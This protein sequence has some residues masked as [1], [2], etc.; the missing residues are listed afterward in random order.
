MKAVLD[1]GKTN[2]KLQLVDDSGRALDSFARKNTPLNS[3]PY[4]HADVAGIWSWLLATLASYGRVGEIEALIVTTHGATA[5]LVNENLLGAS[6]DG[7]VLPVLDYEYPAIENCS[8][9]YRALRPPFSETFSPDLPAGLNL[10]RQ[11]FWLEQEFGAEFARASHILMYPQYWAWRL[12]GQLAGEVTSLGCHTDLWA[13]AANRYSSLVERCGWQR[14]LP[15]LQS[16]WQE[17]GLLLPAIALHTGLPS[18]CKIYVGLHDSNASYLR[19]LANATARADYF[20]VISSGTWTILM[21]ARGGVAS[22]N[23][24]RDMLANCDVY[25]D[26][27]PCARF[28]GGREYELI[29]ARLGGDMAAP[30]SAAEVQQAIDQGWMVTPDFSA[31]NGPFGGLEARLNC[32]LPAPSAGAIATLYCALMI[33]QRLSDLGASGPI[34]IEGAFLNN[35][36]LCQLVAQ[37]RSE[38][39]VY[40]SADATGTVQG[41]LLLTRLANSGDFTLELQ[42]CAPA[43]FTGLAEYR[44]QWQ[45]LIAGES[46]RQSI[47]S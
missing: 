28:M 40:L 25:G 39:P 26:P 5:A 10:G 38:Q 20:T 18:G 19:Y 46:E 7:L 14:L 8:P 22:L 13:P 17:L 2:V 31:G 15:P 23:S 37:L 45:V 27:V 43:R 16:A 34:Y 3:A 29:C 1:I 44:T 35:Q 47:K 9:A 24:G 33:D 21:L 32:P 12:T 6:A 4:P 11:I 36:Q 30:V 41:A 42:S